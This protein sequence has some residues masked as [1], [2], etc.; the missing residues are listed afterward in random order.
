MVE[1]VIFT[2]A[3]SYNNSPLDELLANTPIEKIDLAKMKLFLNLYTT[4]VKTDRRFMYSLEADLI[5]YVTVALSNVEITSRD[6]EILDFYLCGYTEKE[7]SRILKVSINTV[8]KH[9]KSSIRKII[10]QLY[11][12]VGVEVKH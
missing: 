7:I 5:D 9:L 12:E 6:R 11:S 2:T 10:E 3:Q 4:K 8:N 1:K